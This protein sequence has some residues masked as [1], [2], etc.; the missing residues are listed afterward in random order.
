LGRFSGIP[1]TDLVSWGAAIGGDAN[2]TSVNPFYSSDAELSINHTILWEAGDPIT[3]I[4]I[5]IDS[6]LRDAVKPDIGARS[7]VPCSNDAGIDVI[8]GINHSVQPGVQDIRAALRNHGTNTL[9]SVSIQWSVNGQPQTV[10]NWTGSLTTKQVDTISIGLFDF[11]PGEL[12]TIRV[13]TENPNGVSD[14]NPVNNQTLLEN[15]ATP[16]SGTYT[17]GGM[18][19]DFVDFTEAVT[20]L[21]TAGIVGPVNFMVRDGYYDEQ[22]V[23]GKITGSGPVNRIRFIGESGDSSLAV[24]RYNTDNSILDYA[25]KLDGAEYISFETMG[26]DRF[27]NGFIIRLSSGSN[28][29]SFSR[30]YL[31]GDGNYIRSD[32]GSSLRDIS[33]EGTYSTARVNLFSVTNLVFNNN[34]FTREIYLRDMDTSL[35]DGN[36]LGGR[37][38]YSGQEL[39]FT[40]NTCR[41]LYISASNASSGDIKLMNNIIQ[42]LISFDVRLG[43]KSEI[44]SNEINAAGQDFAIYLV[45]SNTYEQ[46]EIS[47]NKIYNVSNKRGIVSHARNAIIS[48]NFI[49]T[50]GLGQAIGIQ[51]NTRDNLVAFNSVNNLSTNQGSQGIVINEGTGHT[52]KN[53]IFSTPAGGV[54]IE[55]AVPLSGCDIDYNN[56]YTPGTTLGRFSGIPYT[57]LVSWGAAI[58]GDAN[59]TTNDPIY[60]SDTELRPYQRYMNGA[61]IPVGS[62]L[63]DIDGEI[64]NDAAPDMGADE[65]IADF[66]ITRLIGPTLQCDLTSD[67]P[68]IINIRQFGD[69]PFQELIV[70]Y[71]VNEGVIHY[72]TLPGSINNDIEHTFPATEDLSTE[73]VYSFKIWLANANDDNNQNDTLRVERYKKPSPVVDFSFL[74]ACAHQNVQFVGSAN[75]TPGSIDRYE[76]DFG[77]GIQSD[78]QNPTHI[79]DFSET[80]SVNFKAYSNEGCYTEAIKDVVITTTPIVDFTAEDVCSGEV[81]DFMNNSTVQVGSLTYNWD[82]GD[83]NNSNVESPGHI[84]AIPGKYYVQLSAIAESGCIASKQDTV[85]M[86]ETIDIDMSASLDTVWAVIN[87]GVNPYFI[88]WDNGSTETIQTDLDRGWHF[89][90]VT[91]SKNCSAIDSIEVIIPQLQ[92]T[93][94]GTDASCMA[95][96]DGSA[97]VTINQGVAPYYYLWS[98]GATTQNVSGLVPGMYYV[99]VQD[100][101]LDAWQDSIYIDGP[102]SF[103]ISTQA[104]HLECFNGGGGAI[105]LTITGGLP[106]IA[107]LWSNGSTDEDLDSLSA[108]MYWVYVTDAN[109][110]IRT[111]TVIITQPEGMGI[112]FETYDV[113]CS[114][115]C[116]GVALVS[117]V[118]GQAPY[119]YDWSNGETGLFQFNLCADDYGLTI[120]DATGCTRDTLFT[121]HEPDPMFLALN[122]QDVS[123]GGAADGAVMTDISGGTAPY[124]FNWDNGDTTQNIG[125]I[126]GGF[127]SLTVTDANGCMAFDIVQVLEPDA[128]IINSVLTPPTCTGN[129]DGAIDVTVDGG[130]PG[131]T[132]LWKDGEITEDISGLSA[133][134]YIID[135]TDAAGCSD[136]MVFYLT[137]P[138]PLSVN[139]DVVQ[140]SCNGESD[141]SVNADVMGGT[142]PYSYTW[143]TGAT[144]SRIENL[145]D[146][147][148]DLT[149]RDANN[150][151]TS[152]SVDILSPELLM[153]QIT[154]VNPTCEGVCNGSLAADVTGGIAPYSYS[155]NSS[156]GTSVLSDLCEGRYELTVTDANGCAYTTWVDLIWET[157]VSGTVDVSD[158]TCEGMCNGYAIAMGAGGDGAFTYLW[159]DGQTGSFRN[160]LCPGGLYVSIKDGQGCEII[161]HDSIHSPD[162]IFITGITD[163]ANCKDEPSGSIILDISGGTPDF[164]YN[165]NSGATT[166]DLAG[167]IAG[168][169]VVT[170]HDAN[171]CSAVEDFTVS[172]PASSISLIGT[173]TDVD[174]YGS[175]T[176]SI[177]L[178]IDGGTSPYSYSWS[179]GSAERDQFN[180]TA[181]TYEVTVTDANGCSLVE[182][183]SVFEPAAAL[184]VSGEISDVDCRGSATGSVILTVTGGTSPYDYSWITGSV[185]KDQTGLLAGIYE[186]T[187]TDA[188]ACTLVQ[189]FTVTEPA[190]SLVVTGIVTNASCNGSATGSVELSVEGGTSP[191]SF[192]WT[193]GSIEED[194]SSLLAGVYEVTVTDANGCQVVDEFTISEPASTISAI[195]TVT[196]IACFSSATGSIELTVEGGTSP[197]DYN[198]TN[199]SSEKDQSDLQTGT[200]QVTVT[201]AN[202]CTL[203]EEFRITEPA[204]AVF[205]TGTVSGVDCYGMETGSIVLT[206]EGGISPYS[207]NWT[208]GS[209][210]KDQTGLLAGSY[211]VTVTDANACIKIEEYVV[212]APASALSIAGAVT[213]AS[214]HG[215]STGSIVLSISGGTAP[216]SYSWTNGS[217]EKD[218]TALLTGSYKVTV[219]DANACVVSKEFTIGEP[220][221]ALLVSGTVYDGDCMG[222]ANGNIMLV[223]EGGT[224]PYSYSW[225]NGSTDKNQIGVI[226]G[227]Y[228]VAVTDSKG[229]ESTW[230]GEVFEKAKTSL[231]GKVQFSEGFVTADEADVVLLD[232]ASHPYRTVSTVRVQPEGVFRFS[233][234]P[235]GDYIIYVKL[236]NHAKQKYKGVMHS[237]YNKTH[238][239]K[240]AQILNILC[241][242]SYAITLDMFENPAATNG[243]G[244]VSGKCKYDKGDT[245]SD[246]PPVENVTVILIDESTGL[247]VGY[248]ETDDQGYYEFTGIPDGNY[249][250]YVDFPGVD[251]TSTHEF[252]IDATNLVHEGLDYEVDVTLEF[253][254]SA[255]E[256]LTIDVN[257]LPDD[258]VVE[259]FPNPAS[260]YVVLRSPAFEDNIVKISIYSEKGAL[261]RTANEHEMVSQGGQIELDLRDAESGNYII[262]IEMDDRIIIKRFILIK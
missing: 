31:R 99:T 165:W 133:G 246:A 140:P 3:G 257:S 101:Y 167:I 154:S 13:W 37:F 40:E 207:Y 135:V 20:V 180:L 187:I 39:S 2:S 111:D 4:D 66:G 249:S 256:D 182:V 46:I 128:I 195:S 103:S 38:E 260:Q 199:G 241:E 104:T 186:V 198:W 36:H 120:T 21:N 226:A 108:G 96:P 43:I 219:T 201:D 142:L 42:G 217:T 82:F 130:Q 61:G 151:E 122:P 78:L 252:T 229:C 175:T 235:A 129:S 173:T 159:S 239:W 152:G 8:A 17:I 254:I 81:M 53:N 29:I 110:N 221:G 72:D 208:N 89:V 158:V 76:W 49:Q 69:I 164:V 204:S 223:V 205:I 92:F 149:V 146:G 188:N 93:V 216:Y 247:P 7:Y 209:A 118:G 48:N 105:D 211:E 79:Y 112:D 32:L 80:Y 9:T 58:G 253:V 169:Y 35:I 245:K 44:I 168:Y 194:Q 134:Q 94:S 34:H 124:S 179:N 51:I 225:S 126:P 259:L 68:V 1:Y 143:S 95:C 172:E 244:K 12:Y 115:N 57:D 41:N 10:F 233:D 232:A 162:P 236:D 234:I 121:I 255:V 160:N 25:L 153:V 56:Y 155:W 5:D 23:I 132:Y 242:E 174:C 107:V 240:E 65:F 85:E 63:L 150:C 59:S 70:A 147:V 117:V 90:T 28:N 156:P 197:Y 193:N 231:S 45:N 11:D 125:G 230:S 161:L 228:N 50:D 52:I 203:I 131:F 18:T 14:C 16:L 181:G 102:I 196:D 114:D 67:E 141:A 224:Y 222:S 75:V 227:M 206:V 139:M 144:T 73:G 218:Q 6:L 185:D 123:C 192:S 248:V 119:S 176:G 30:C 238:K 15:I 262:R 191:Y 77:D 26:V 177:L 116:N 127:Y 54:P 183:F 258:M 138:L 87:G 202:G 171:G 83:G 163:D 98:N 60:E 109:S 250:I 84:Y 136:T 86:F 62:V 64:R 157:Q 178:D 55:I 24:L 251:Q 189:E 243:N 106:P 100:A 33:L 220:T 91:D 200:Y 215:S 19:P 88:Q 74:T 47:G 212:S 210:E 27:A 71:Q 213:D 170:V 148:Y 166:K 145:S 190:A 22:I 237:Y 113:S 261:L 184:E 214:C 97:G 137:E